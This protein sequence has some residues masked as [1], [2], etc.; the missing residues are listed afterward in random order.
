[1][2]TYQKEMKFSLLRARQ[3]VACGVNIIGETAGFFKCF[4]MLKK[5]NKMVRNKY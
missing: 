2:L 4:L 3:Y 1:M 5:K